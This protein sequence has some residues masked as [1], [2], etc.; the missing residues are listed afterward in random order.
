MTRKLAPD[1][2]E[3]LSRADT[4]VKTPP[5][6][7][8]R[9]QQNIAQSPAEPEVRRIY[10]GD[11]LSKTPDYAS[12]PINKHVVP[13]KRRSTFSIIKVLFLCAFGIVFYIGN[14]LTVNQLAVEVHQLQAQYDRIVNN[15]SVLKAGINRKSAMERIGNTAKEQMGLTYRKERP[16]SFDVDGDKLEQFKD[17]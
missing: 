2:E 6:Q 3:L 12:R 8:S 15:N 11:A 7:K 1:L 5:R 16:Q 9:Q 17:K 4:D 14:I 10:S 13:K